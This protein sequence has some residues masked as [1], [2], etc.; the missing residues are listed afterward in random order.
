[1]RPPPRHPVASRIV[2]V[3]GSGPELAPLDEFCARIVQVAT[4]GDFS[5]IS[6]AR[7]F[8]T[9]MCTWMSYAGGEI[10]RASGFGTWTLRNATTPEQSPRHDWLVQGDLFVDL[11]AHQFASAGFG[12]F[13]VGRGENPLTKR[14]VQ[15]IRDHPTSEI[16]DHPAIGD[17]RDRLVELLDIA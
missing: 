2:I 7:P 8:P 5:D 14:F 9:G 17:Y 13:I 12:T 4:D 16:V 10:L 11:T 15:H 1:M 3:S 6:G